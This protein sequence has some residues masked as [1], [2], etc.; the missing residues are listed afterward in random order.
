VHQ[1][2]VHT[3]GGVIQPGEP[4]MLIVPSSDALS[5]EAKVAPQDGD[6]VVLWRLAW[7]AMADLGRGI[8][9]LPVRHPLVRVSRSWR[10]L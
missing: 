1:L 8:V 5:V 4:I 7:L 3:V 6:R 2:A 9:R 10:V